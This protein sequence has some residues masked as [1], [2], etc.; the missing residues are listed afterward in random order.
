MSRQ[1]L[2]RLRGAR[3]EAGS[4]LAEMAVIAPLIML[5]L[6]GLVELGRY[7]QFS[8]IVGNA[9]R[10]GV[11]YGSQN[12]GT[13]DD[14]SGMQSAA[15]TDAQSISGVSATATQFCRCADGS[16]STCQSTDCPNSHRLVFVQVDV[17][18]TFTSILHMPGVP[19][20]Q[21]ITSRAVMRV[22]Q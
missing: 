15:V 10:A 18:G 2:S 11:Q 19:S 3:G 13:A 14:T 20:S 21:R 22:A 9:A 8:V 7:A 12:L 16:T 1:V 17:S 4:A 5:V 6:I